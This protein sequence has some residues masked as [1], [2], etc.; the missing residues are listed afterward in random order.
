MNH[1]LG[2][3]QG[4]IRTVLFWRAA[5]YVF[6]KK[7]LRE[8]YVHKHVLCVTIRHGPWEYYLGSKMEY[9]KGKNDFVWNICRKQPRPTEIRILPIQCNNRL[10]VRVKDHP[11]TKGTNVTIRNRHERSYRNSQPTSRYRC[12]Y[13][14][15]LYLE[16]FMAY[17]ENHSIRLLS[18]VSNELNNDFPFFRVPFRRRLPWY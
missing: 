8:K 2:H 5:V 4:M 3:G 17:T 15:I 6:K 16:D 14:A 11:I 18:S 1:S 9:T 13:S 12:N 7:H 10:S